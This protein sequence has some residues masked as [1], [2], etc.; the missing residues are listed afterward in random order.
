MRPLK[1]KRQHIY[2]EHSIENIVQP[3]YTPDIKNTYEDNTQPRTTS[4]KHTK[5]LPPTPITQPNLL[6]IFETKI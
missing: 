3:K 5:N 4:K 6:T 1:S 2:A